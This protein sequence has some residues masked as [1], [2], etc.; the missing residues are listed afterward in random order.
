MSLGWNNV[1]AR[2][3]TISNYMPLFY[4]D[5]I[6][7]SYLNPDAGLPRPQELNHLDDLVIRMRYHLK[8][9]HPVD[10]MWYL[11]RMTLIPVQYV[12]RVAFDTPLNHPNDLAP[13]GILVEQIIAYV[14]RIVQ[15]MI[16]ATDLVQIIYR[17]HPSRKKRGPR[18]MSIWP[19]FSN[20][21]AMG[22][23]EILFFALK[24]Q[25]MVGKDNDNNKFY[26]LS[27]ENVQ[28]ML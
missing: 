12:I 8:P 20:M 7:Y 2:W 22:Y 26:V 16:Q 19:P 10:S 5:V 24:G 17:G 25:Q 18:K 11:A 1:F 27:I 9:S 4:M 13:D 23:P 21:A 6:T 3:D 14:R 28:L 15:I